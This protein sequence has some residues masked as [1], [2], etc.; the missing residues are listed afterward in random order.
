MSS[1]PQPLVS[2]IIGT[3]NTK[4]FDDLKKSLSS[5]LNQSYENIEVV[6]CDDMS[7]NGTYEFLLNE[8][9]TNKSIKIIR[10]EKNS[11]LGYSLNHCLEFTKGEFIARH[12]DD[13]YITLDKIE[14]QVNFLLSHPDFDFVSTGYYKF[15]KNGIWDKCIPLRET[16]SKRDFRVGTQHVHASTVFRRSCLNAVSGYRISV[17]T[18]RLEDYDLFMRLYASGFKGYNIREPLYFYNFPRGNKRKIRF[19]NK[20]F[21][22]KVRFQGFKRLNLKWYDYIYVLKPII[23]GLLPYAIISFLK[24]ID[25]KH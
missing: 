24:K 16:P 10:N 15:D 25:K 20:I 1:I 23:I 2:F 4:D 9:G 5:V 12:D 18:K 17:E 14:R 6:I 11:G 22:A 7:T 19:K 21:E 13:D 3:Y 8:Y